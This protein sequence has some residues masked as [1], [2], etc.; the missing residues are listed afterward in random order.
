[1]FFI[2]IHFRGDAKWCETMFRDE[3]VESANARA[4]H[5]WTGG[6]LAAIRVVDITGRIYFQ[7]SQQ[8]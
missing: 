8:S 6:K 7:R 2:D 5:L 4:L 3:S 1:M